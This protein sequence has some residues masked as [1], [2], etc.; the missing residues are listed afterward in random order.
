MAGGPLSPPAAAPRG[1]RQL[2]ADSAI[3]MLDQALLSALNLGLGLLLIRLTA[4]ESYGLYAQLFAGGLFATAVLEALVTG[5]LNNVAAGL[6]VQRR[7]AVIGHLARFQQWLSLALALLS[8]AVVAAG[9]A[10]TG[11]DPRPGWLGAAFAVYVYA[12]SLREYARSIGFLEGRVGDVLKMDGLYA[13]AVVAGMSVLTVYGLLALP[14]VVFV[15]GLSN[16]AAL[17]LRRWP[18]ADQDDR[19]GGAVAVAALWRLGRWA[20]PGALVSWAANY[21]YLYLAA[22]WLG[23]TASADLNAARLLLMPISL[24]VI[25][26]SRTARPHAAQLL[27]QRRLRPLNRYVGLSV[28]A[29]ELLTATYV[30]LLWLALPW[31]EVH[32]LGPQYR[33]LHALVLAWGLYFALSAA[34][35]AGSSLLASAGRYRMLLVVS[36]LCA[37]VMLAVAFYTIPLWGVQGAVAALSVF[38]VA[39]LLL[40][41]LVLWPRVRRDHVGAAR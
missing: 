25:A 32:L 33:G 22:L 29:L 9:V 21:S 20:L 7:A 2:L 3:S 13:F 1:R 23:A 4:K 12:G 39:C 15:L 27:A 5:P 19:A 30:G 16:L 8:G 11:A 35:T 38:E 36:C 6:D 41:W 10:V 37:A 34:R 28:A 31:L 26:W 17:A 14:A 40:I 18:A 24:C